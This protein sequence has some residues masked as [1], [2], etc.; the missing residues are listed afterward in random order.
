MF[1]G[2]EQRQWLIQELRCTHALQ[3]QEHMVKKADKEKVL[4]KQEEQLKK[5]LKVS[6]QLIVYYMSI[7]MPPLFYNC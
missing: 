1:A 6:N 2:K 3:P 4:R 7:H 5:K